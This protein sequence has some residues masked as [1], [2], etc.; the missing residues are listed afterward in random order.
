GCGCEP[1]I[2]MGLSGHAGPISIGSSADVGSVIRRAN[3]GAYIAGQ[4]QIGD[5]MI[6][7]DNRGQI[8]AQGGTL[9]LDTGAY[10]I[11]NAGK[12]DATA[13]STLAVESGVNNYGLILAAGSHVEGDATVNLN[14]GL[15]NYS[16]LDAGA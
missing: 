4:G 14:A 3:A 5:A 11:N 2:A 6:R 13:A 15:N 9:T 7:L 16:L 10:K 8:E 12:L 1:D